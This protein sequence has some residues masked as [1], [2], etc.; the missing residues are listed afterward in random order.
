VK[1]AYDRVQA[2]HLRPLLEAIARELDERS[3]AI[4]RQTRALRKLRLATDPDEFRI[5][6]CVAE[7]ALHKREMR[8]AVEELEQLGCV[9]EPGNHAVI[10][11]PGPDGSL[12]HGYQFSPGA[13]GAQGGSGLATSGAAHSS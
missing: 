13:P 4:R 2:E 9:A 5:A 7:L 6:S 8:H 10:L 11:V 1:R 3:L 12:E